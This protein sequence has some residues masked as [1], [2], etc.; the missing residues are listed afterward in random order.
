MREREER[1][2]EGETREGGR[3]RQTKEGRG[4]RRGIIIHFICITFYVCDKCQ[5]ATFKGQRN[6]AK[7]IEMDKV[8]CIR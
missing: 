1:E 6:I 3:E 5:S 2:A 8:T 4:G 7:H